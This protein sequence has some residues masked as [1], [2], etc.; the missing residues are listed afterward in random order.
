MPFYL[1]TISYSFLFIYLFVSAALLEALGLQGAT[2][3][4]LALSYFRR[5]ELP[6]FDALL[7]QARTVAV[8]AAC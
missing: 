2:N 3:L 1:F 5:N 8:A 4:L 6:I 7:S